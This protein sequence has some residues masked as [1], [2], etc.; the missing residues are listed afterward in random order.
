MLLSPSHIEEFESQLT[1]RV[2]TEDKN[3]EESALIMSGFTNKRV[4]FSN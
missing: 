3:T 1:D 2:Y 4:S